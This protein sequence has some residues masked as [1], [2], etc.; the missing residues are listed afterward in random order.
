MKVLVTGGSGF[1]G[2]HVVDKLRDKGVDVRIYDMIMPTFCKN[3]EYYQGSILD[4][5][6]LGMAMHGIDAIF[7]LAAVA[8]VKDVFE[9]PHYSEAIN[10]RGTINIL[11][12]ARRSKIRVIYGSTTW[13]YSDTQGK[14][15][16]ESTPLQAPFHLYTATKL[17]GEY[18]C[19]NYSNLYG[20]ETTILRYGIPYG[21]RARDGAVVPIFV[22]KALK[23]EPLTIAGDG[24]QFRKFVYVEDLAEGNVLALKSIAKN[25]I[26]NLDGNEQ[27]SIRQIA[28]TI[29][30]LIG[31]VKIEYI[32]ART[33]DFSG[34]EISS[35]LAK[36][37]LGWEPKVR[38]EE[39]VRRYIEWYKDRDQKRKESWE[40]ID[41]NLK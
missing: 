35:E 15:V 28:E 36:N 13:V 18:Y 17:A 12:A 38:F 16:D 1:I 14:K 9:S 3:I 41:S 26:Y 33:G 20:I 21:P 27:V 22:G 29:Q 32:P 25:K 31:D 10:V 4:D 39:G 40:K 5:M 23:G 37:E 24:S 11:E 19:K 30:K 7:H 6:T 34:K 2:S 8:D